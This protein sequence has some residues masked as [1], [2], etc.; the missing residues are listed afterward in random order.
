MAD[1]VVTA[2]SV[3]PGAGAVIAQG[4]A[5]ETITAGQAVALNS[6]TGLYMKADA[7]N[8]TAA[9]RVAAGIALCGASNGQPISVQT[10]GKVTLNAA[11]TASEPF[12]LSATAGGICPKAD[13][14]TGMYTQLIGMADS[15]T[16]LN[17]GFCSS[18]A[19]HA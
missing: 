17:L 19:A 9:L 4:T 16:V 8:A 10:A 12:F 14:A 1:I 18:A 3:L 6:A 7:D 2:A 5:G 13:I 15:T 11:L